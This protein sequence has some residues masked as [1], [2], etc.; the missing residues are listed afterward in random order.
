MKP[1]HLFRAGDRVRLNPEPLSGWSCQGTVDEDQ[2]PGEP[3]VS[4]L[5]DDTP[6]GMCRAG[7]AHWS[8]LE[9]IAAQTP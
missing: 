9:R 2:A 3:L 7:Y 6:A 4:F 8:E 5:R 1:P